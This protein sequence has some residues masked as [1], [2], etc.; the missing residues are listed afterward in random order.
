MYEYGIIQDS[1][2]FGDISILLN[3]PSDY[4]YYNYNDSD[5]TMLILDAKQFL[6][7]C[8]QHPFSR[9][10]L[11]ENAQKRRKMFENYKTKILLKMMKTIVNKPNI[12]IEKE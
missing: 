12:A 3:Q 10:I 2:Y 8:N 1:S 5:I 6:E 4:A 9:D 11:K 7:I